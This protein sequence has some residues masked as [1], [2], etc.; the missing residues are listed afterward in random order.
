MAEIEKKYSDFQTNECEPEQQIQIVDEKLC[1][2]CEP[3]PNFKLEGEWWDIEKAYLNEK[4][5]E[6]Q[7][8]VY[9]GHA[10]R[11]LEADG[12]GYF[13]SQ[14]LEKVQEKILELA[15]LKILNEFDKPINDS[16]KEQVFATCD[17]VDEY[18]GT[19]SARLGTAYLVSVPAFNFDQVLPKDDPN[20]EQGDRQ[21]AF[22]SGNEIILDGDTLYRKMLVLRLTIDSYG[23]FYSLAQHAAGDSFVIRQERNPVFR[24]NYDNTAKR[25]RNFMFDLSDVMEEKNYPRLGELGVFKTKRPER[26]NHRTRS[27]KDCRRTRKTI[28]ATY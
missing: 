16:T 18:Y 2:T 12:D 15:T 24:I 4:I 19:N 20:A 26:K 21:T 14:K 7:V 17:I 6:Y 22:T 3:N 28:T 10:K 1:P 13:E 27:N 23:K 8:R 11:E 5:C 9:E 25:V